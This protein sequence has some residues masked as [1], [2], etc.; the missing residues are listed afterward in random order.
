MEKI[1]SD[2]VIIGG[3]LTGLTLAYHLRKRNKKVIIL[4]ARERLGGRILSIKNDDEAPLEMGATWIHGHHQATLGLIAELGL[5]VFEQA[6]GEYAIYDVSPQLSPQIVNFPSSGHPSF[7]IED[8]SSQLID[9]LASNIDSR[10]IYLGQN[11][12]TINQIE[13]AIFC[14]SDTHTFESKLVVSTL[15]PHLF[16]KKIEVSPTLPSSLTSVTHNTGTWMGESIRIALSYR[17]RFWKKDDLEGTIFSKGGPIFEMYDH[18]NGDE[19]RYGLM[20]FM[21]GI[22]HMDTKAVRRDL[23]IKQLEKYYGSV[24]NDFISYEELVWKNEVYTSTRM[25]RFMEPRNNFGHEI[26]QKTFL[27]GMLIFAGTETSKQE[28]GFM[29]GA[30]LS[31]KE[32]DARIS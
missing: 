19:S 15:P 14:L 18:S 23:V 7:R 12:T 5:S 31:A 2:I 10:D 22:Y 32:I 11:I 16:V 26:Y 25:S 3:G 13:G 8:G 28:A 29:E 6:F 24:V 27:D 20:G 21:N 4:E 17:E 30:V 1:K 9:R